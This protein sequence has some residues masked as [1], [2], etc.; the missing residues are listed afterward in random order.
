MVHQY[1]RNFKKSD[2]RSIFKDGYVFTD[3]QGFLSWNESKE[4][5]YDGRYNDI[6]QLCNLHSLMRLKNKNG[7]WSEQII[8]W[9]FPLDFFSLFEKCYIC[10]YLW[11]GSMQRAYFDLHDIEYLHMTLK[12]G[13]LD[14]YNPSKELEVRSQKWEL[15][16]LYN[17][18][19]NK[20]GVPDRK[21]RNP[22]SKS[23][24]GDKLKKKKN[25]C[26]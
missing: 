26:P 21:N 10:T 8:M 17:G 1:D 15:I 12:D 7:G 20:I 24:Y 16:N 22:L 4:K 2:L 25:I 13:K 6:K 3:E 14:F 5:N 9:N 23:W 18:N 11:D 19:L